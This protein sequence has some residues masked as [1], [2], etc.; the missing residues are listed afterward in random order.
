MHEGD[1]Q[2]T[3]SRHGEE[4]GMSKSRF[5]VLVALWLT[6]TATAA[7]AESD[8]IDFNAIVAATS[9]CEGLPLGIVACGTIGGHEDCTGVV[10][11]SFKSKVQIGELGKSSNPMCDYACRLSGSCRPLVQ[12]VNWRAESD[13]AIIPAGVFK[14]RIKVPLRAF[15]MEGLSDKLADVLNRR[16]K[17]PG[18][19]L[20]VETIAAEIPRDAQGPE[21]FS[22]G[23]LELLP[24]RFQMAREQSTDQLMLLVVP[25]MSSNIDGCYKDRVILL[26]KTTDNLMLM[27]EVGHALGL[28]HVDGGKEL[29]NSLS[30]YRN[31]LS[32]REMAI[33]FL[34][35]TSAINKFGCRPLEEFVLPMDCGFP[36]RCETCPR[37]INCYRGRYPRFKTGD[38]D[39]P[40]ARNFSADALKEALSGIKC[41]N[42]LEIGRA[43]V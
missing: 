22:C 36:P 28:C 2:G 11:P 40:S 23:H 1:I 10:L 34:E 18:F 26:P 31:E 27:H 15:A 16:Q 41:E 29:M 25:K 38:A 8:R 6:Y 24:E 30:V 42:E 39:F 12:N 4:R 17:V 37:D 13:R 21:E 43:H 14:D 5:G 7:S 35:P 9:S 20:D 32:V 19:D 3:L 33:A